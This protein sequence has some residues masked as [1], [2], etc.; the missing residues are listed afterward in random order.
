MIRNKGRKNKEEERMNT[1]I[2]DFITAY[3]ENNPVRFHMPGHKGRKQLGPED[4]DI[5]EIYGADS[6]YEAEGIIA[7]SEKNASLLFNSGATFYSTEGSS[8][9]IKAMLYLMMSKQKRGTERPYLIAARNAHKSLIHGAALLDL[10][11]LWWYPKERTSLCSALVDPEDLEDLLSIRKE[12]PI[13]VYVTCPDYLG[14]LLPLCEIAE[15]CHKYETY[16]AVD[17]AHG[18]YLHFL[19]NPCHPLDLGADF[20]C[21]SA[22]KTLPV[23]TGGAYLHL[24]KSLGKEFLGKE[25]TALSFFGSTSPSY[26]T[27][28]SLDLCNVYL[29]SRCKEELQET[30]KRAEELKEKL[31][32][33]GWTLEDTEPLKITF[34]INPAKEENAMDG[35]HVREELE[36]QGIYPEYGDLDYL[37]LMITTEN[38]REDFQQLEQALKK[39]RKE[40]RA[41]VKENSGTYWK[42][43]EHE[44]VLTLREAAFLP[45]EEISAECSVGR[46]CAIPT[47][48]CPPAIPIVVS[49]E[50]IRKEDIA[51]FAYYGIKKICV[52]KEE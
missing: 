40:G 47:V 33:Q 9:C 18:A 13:G 36:K 24:H 20:C 3:R 52:V 15:I 21:D 38:T 29:Q 6:L 22:H 37:V 46:I 42:I 12:R 4:W 34:R 51:T 19:N 41:K 43:Q 25:K 16:L 39:I 48:S 27:L 45:N 49:G 17:N 28:A 11:I 32:K 44:Q 14:N 5:T 35:I 2:V 10:D 50:R 31:R 8:Q 23:L 30:I 7:Q 1:P 26:L